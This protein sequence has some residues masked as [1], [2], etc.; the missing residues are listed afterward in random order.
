MRMKNQKCQTRQNI[1]RTARTNQHNLSKVG[2]PTEL[3]GSEADISMSQMLSALSIPPA[4]RREQLHHQRKGVGTAATSGCVSLASSASA[5]TG[6][7]LDDFALKTDSNKHKWLYHAN[8]CLSHNAVC[9]SLT[10][11][12]CK[13]VF[14]NTIATCCRACMLKT[15]LVIQHKSLA[16]VGLSPQHKR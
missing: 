9:M 2:I 3:V 1:S 6:Q 10:N 5:Q 12:L 11:S 7:D 14:P 15:K 4:L 16:T 8:K 13:C